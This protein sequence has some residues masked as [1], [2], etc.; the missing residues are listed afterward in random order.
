MVGATDTDAT[1]G[2][3][4][5]PLGVRESDPGAARRDREGRLWLGL[6][7]IGLGAIFLLDR[8][9]PDIGAYLPLLVGLGFFVAFLATRAYGFLIP[10]G[11]VSGVGAGI[12][13]QQTYD[14]GGI[15]LLALGGGFVAIW[16]IGAL[17][18]LR[19]HHW[20]PLIPGGILLTIGLV[21][22]ADES[23]PLSELLDIGWPILL[24]AVGLLVIVRAL[25]ER[26]ATQP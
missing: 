10:A 23:G 26:R 18:R 7:L 2:D 16:L 11:I 4:T 12:L 21:D 13:L 6:I 17:F 15:F 3:D 9:V 25:A 24:V 1:A 8:V 20:W 19:E 14:Q 22:L 5:P